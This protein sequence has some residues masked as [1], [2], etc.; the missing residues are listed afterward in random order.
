MIGRRPSLPQVAP[1]AL[2]AGAAVAVA[3][4]LALRP[5]S[6]LALASTA[7]FAT[8]IA[9][10]VVERV[11]SDDWLN[12]ATFLLV[13]VALGFGLRG[14][15]LIWGDSHLT[16]PAWAPVPLRDQLATT[17]L[18]TATAGVLATYCGYTA[19]GRLARHRALVRPRQ[20][21]SVRVR[22]AVRTLVAIGVIG[23]AALIQRLGGVSYFSDLAHARLDTSGLGIFKLASLGVRFALLLWLA[24]TPN[25][26]R[27]RLILGCAVVLLLTTGQRSA[28]FATLIPVMIVYHN[29]VRRLPPRTVALVAFGAV[30]LAVSLIVYRQHTRV[31]VT[32]RNPAVASTR[33]QLTSGSDIFRSALVSL[34]GLV[35]VQQAVPT[36]Q[37][38]N[39][40][41]SL[42]LV[43]EGYVPRSVW[44]G[45]PPWRSNVLASRYLNS[46][47]GG[48]FLSGF[49]TLWAIGLL[50]GVIVGSLVMGAV[51]G[52]AYAR[53]R[54]F[55]S[56]AWVLAYAVIALGA[57]RFML[58][59]D[60]ISLFFATQAVGAIVIVVLAV[61]RPRPRTLRPA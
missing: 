58:A 41:R 42:A 46:A 56:P 47:H 53:M 35:L 10:T 52:W 20:F 37:Q 59:G 27:R 22:W 25:P 4:A 24:T 9:L 49:G 1:V 21:D 43:A 32:P 11:R 54:R 57:A 33:A 39:L 13:P 55:R 51:V 8:C 3:G 15:S 60:E 48:V 50:P 18:W 23:F 29:R 26:S 6:S 7:L 2:A 30:V 16:Y 36:D 28:V 17:A 14:L 40:G 19:G 34:D 31:T 44:A 61:S 12:G 5:P 38:P 45:K